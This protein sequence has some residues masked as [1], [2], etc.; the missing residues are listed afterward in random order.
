MSIQPTEERRMSHAE[1]VLL[2][3]YAKAACPQQA[4]DQYTPD[5][6]ADLLGD[7]RYV[8]CQEAVKAVVQRQPFVAPAEIREEVKRVRSKRILDFGPIPDPGHEIGADP[9]RYRRYMLETTR[10]IADGVLLPGQVPPL[11]AELTR[12]V[13]AEL[14]EAGTSIREDNRN[15]IQ[16]AKRAAA[17]GRKQA[18]AARKPEPEPL[19]GPG[20]MS[21]EPEPVEP[22][23]TEES[24]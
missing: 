1:A 22:E 9:A 5:A 6:W 18:Q 24:A 4:F 13:I 19:L 17:E 21:R 16:Q 14:G 20:D 15:A 2:C 3:R 8:D 7:L 10:D 12:D 23:P 11:I